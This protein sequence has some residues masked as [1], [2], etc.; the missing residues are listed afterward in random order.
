[1]TTVTLHIGAVKTGTTFV[2]NVMSNNEKVLRDLGVLWPGPTWRTQVDA[3]NGLRGSEG[4]PYER[5]TEMVD[6]ISAWQGPAAVMSMEFL[7]LMSQ[8]N[9]HRAIDSLQGHQVRV[10]LTVRGITRAIPAQWQESVQNG[11]SW[12]YQEYLSG[13]TARRPRS[14][15]AGQHFW[16]K[17]DWPQLLRPWTERLDAAD[18]VVV[19]LPTSGAPPG[20]L[21]ERF[22]QAVGLPAERFDAMDRA[23]ESLGAASAE[24][25]RYVTQR[26]IEAG[27]DK[28]TMGTIK[29][30]LAK[31]ML[32]AHRTAEPTLVLPDEYRKWARKRSEELV[33]AMRLVP[34]TVVGDLDELIPQDTR[35]GGDVTSDPSQLPVDS[36]L[37]AAAHGLVSLTEA[38]AHGPRRGSGGPR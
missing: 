20:L 7:S 16:N 30:V 29:R 13:V 11:F 17:Q 4:T 5:W 28:A 35:S 19:T 36:L 21:W 26:A 14:S 8:A 34:A 18:V 37:G 22:C 33:A 23:N 31:Q 38:L 32:A 27:A 6:Q 15:R 10:V 3:V 9:V 12:S 2:Q 1:M 24:V 25:M